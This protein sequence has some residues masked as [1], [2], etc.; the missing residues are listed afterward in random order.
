[1]EK[2]G[3]TVGELPDTCFHVMFLVYVHVCESYSLSFLLWVVCSG[4]KK[5]SKEV[6]KRSWVGGLNF[7][8]TNQQHTRGSLKWFM[9]GF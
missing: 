2:F 5:I 7:N 1:M 9:A 8:P 3:S 4:R 6:R